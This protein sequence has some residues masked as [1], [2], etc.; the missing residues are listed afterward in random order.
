VGQSVRLIQ[1]TVKISTA[2]KPSLVYVA[3]GNNS[4]LFAPVLVHIGQEFDPSA[5]KIFFFIFAG[6]AQASLMIPI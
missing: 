3:K 2:T 5:D 4:D 6:S 1:V